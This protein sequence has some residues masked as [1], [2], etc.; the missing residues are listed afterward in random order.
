MSRL[1]RLSLTTQIVM[2]LALGLV[3]GLVCTHYKVDAGPLGE[4]G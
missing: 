4:I 1:A 2:G 3:Y